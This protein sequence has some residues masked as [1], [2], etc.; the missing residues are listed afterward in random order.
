MEDKQH[1]NKIKGRGSASK[2]DARYLSHTRHEI[3][4]G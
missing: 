1:K 2:P 3:D 4:D